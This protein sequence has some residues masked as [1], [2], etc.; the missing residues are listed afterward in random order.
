MTTNY[1]KEIITWCKY[2]QQQ[3]GRENQTKFQCKRQFRLV[4]HETNAQVKT[5]ANKWFPSQLLRSTRVQRSKSFSLCYTITL[6][7]NSNIHTTRVPILLWTFFFLLPSYLNRCT[8]ARALNSEYN[9]ANR[10][11]SCYESG[12][13]C[14]YSIYLFHYCVNHTNTV[15]EC[16]CGIFFTKALKK[17]SS[18]IALKLCM[19]LVEVFFHY[20]SVA[21]MPFFLLLS[22]MRFSREFHVFAPNGVV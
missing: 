14:P 15:L 20:A 21:C 5:E 6:H 16:S 9:A 12:P 19:R 13:P 17:F 18:T 10:I 11:Q 1:N 7:R 8:L 4:E 3:N 2:K 22:E